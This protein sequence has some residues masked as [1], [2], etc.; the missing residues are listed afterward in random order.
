MLKWI[1]AISLRAVLWAGAGWLLLFAFIYA[2]FPCFLDDLG[3]LKGSPVCEP[4]SIPIAMYISVSTMF[5]LGYSD[6][7]PVGAL[8]IFAAVQV[9]GGVVF[10][11]LAV[12]SIVAMP[13]NHTRLAIR[14]CRGHWVE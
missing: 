2:V 1:D 5:S 12:A 11:G 13:A 8:R 10:A 7:F 4:V 14:A 6:I 9:I 3:E